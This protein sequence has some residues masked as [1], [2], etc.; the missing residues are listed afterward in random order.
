MSNSPSRCNKF[1]LYWHCWVF[2]T[3]PWKAPEPFQ[4]VC[5]TVSTVLKDSVSTSIYPSKPNPNSLKKTFRLEKLWSRME[6]ELHTHTQI[7]PFKSGADSMFKFTKVKGS[8]L[9]AGNLMV[10]V[11]SCKCSLE[12]WKKW[13]ELYLL[14]EKLHTN[15]KKYFLL[16]KPYKKT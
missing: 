15:L 12:G 4:S 5:M 10:V 14:V 1:I 16:S 3:C 11:H 9:S 13:K 8:M 2:A 7:T 6:L